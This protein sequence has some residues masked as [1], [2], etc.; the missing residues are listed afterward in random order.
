MTKL[1][2]KL[3]SEHVQFL[4]DEFGCRVV[5][6]K[7]DNFKD[8][9]IYRNATTAVKV[10]YEP[11]ERS[12]FILLCRLVD[13]NIPQEPIFVRPK[14]KLYSFYLD[15]LLALRSPGA[16]ILR[17]KPFGGITFDDLDAKQIIEACAAAPPFTERDLEH[18]VKTYA[19]ALHK[20]GADIL[21]GDFSVFTELDRIVKK[22]AE[23]F[24]RIGENH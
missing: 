3:C 23:E 20:H 1:F 14:T 5:G 22:R 9:V 24:R 13:G 4:I 6:K 12:M 15:D 7:S 16:R 21:R 18:M 2:F 8:E 19:T 11:R 17:R 10:S